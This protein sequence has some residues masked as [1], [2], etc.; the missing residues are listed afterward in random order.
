MLLGKMNVD[1][2]RVRL[3]LSMLLYDE[4]NV[5]ILDEPTNHLD[6]ESIETLEEALEDFNGTLLFISHDR[7]FINKVCNRV[8][9]IEENKL[10]N[11]PGNYDYYKN[12]KIEWRLAP[13]QSQ[14]VKRPKVI[15]DTV[16]AENKSNEVSLSKLESNIKIL[17]DEV[18]EIDLSM[19]VT[20]LNYDEL[21]NLY[22]KREKLNMEI[23]KMMEEWLIISKNNN[24]TNEA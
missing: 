24:S 17:E 5:L 13:E 11:Y 14:I 16:V 23:D 22:C 21:N 6:I 1:N 7:Y 10:V 18:K 4:T 19:S 2:E 20:G 12:K 15:R 3:K 9:A 8:V